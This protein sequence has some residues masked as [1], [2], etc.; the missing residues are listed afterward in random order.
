M[1]IWKIL[2]SSMEVVAYVKVPDNCDIFDTG[3]AALQLVREQTNDRDVSGTQLLDCEEKMLE[4]I[5][6]YTL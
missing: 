6:I 5:P 4:D 1:K 3:Y 2:K